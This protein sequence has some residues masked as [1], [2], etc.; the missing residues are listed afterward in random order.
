MK[1]KWISLLLAIVFVFSSLQII[2]AEEP[3]NDVKYEVDPM[4]QISEEYTDF[5]PE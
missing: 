4:E 1:R 5:D 3:S 2:V